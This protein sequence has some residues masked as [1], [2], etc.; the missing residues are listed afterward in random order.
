MGTKLRL[1][2]KIARKF[3]RPKVDL[4]ASRINTN[5]RRITW[6]RDPDC[7]TVNAFPVGWKRLKFYAFPPFFII[8]KVLRKIQED[9]ANCI[10][11]VPLYTSQ[12]WFPFSMLIRHT[13]NFKRNQTLLLS[14]NIDPH[15][16]WRDVTLWQELVL[17]S[18]T[19]KR[20]GVPEAT[21]NICL[22]STTQPTRKQYNTGLKL[23]WQFCVEKKIDVFS[24]T[25]EYL[26]K[27]LTYQFERGICYGSLNS[28]SEHCRCR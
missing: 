4:F 9:Q 8:L 2:Q 25:V 11:L 5:A 13:L 27:F 7:T 26:L 16:L 3:F 19:L 12:P 1:F 17:S 24:V 28:Y 23:W 20:K 10:V 18:K 6:R 14:P 21:L 15:T 22:A